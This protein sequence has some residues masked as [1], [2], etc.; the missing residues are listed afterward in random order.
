M[1][2]V[3]RRG[4]SYDQSGSQDRPDPTRQIAAQHPKSHSSRN[5][6]HRCRPRSCDFRAVMRAIA[7]PRSRDS[8]SPATSRR[9]SA[10]SARLS[11]AASSPSTFSEGLRGRKWIGNERRDCLACDCRVECLSGSLHFWSSRKASFT[12]ISRTFPSDLA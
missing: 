1:R 9:A 4:R 10:C 6:G 2:W 8:I 5:P 12:Q 3:R 11:G 7:Q